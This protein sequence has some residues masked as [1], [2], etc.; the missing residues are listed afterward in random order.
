MP[1]STSRVSLLSAG[2]TLPIGAG[3]RWTGESGLKL[4]YVQVRLGFSL[5][6]G[7][8]PSFFFSQ[9]IDKRSGHTASNLGNFIAPAP[10]L[11]PGNKNNP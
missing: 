8:S 1:V 3:S 10:D 2:T 7:F 5:I 4:S 6:R 9:R 11:A